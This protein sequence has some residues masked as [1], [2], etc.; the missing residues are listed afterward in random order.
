[1]KKKNVLHLILL[2]LFVIP[3]ALNAQQ[4][5]QAN[6]SAKK[7]STRIQSD[8]TIGYATPS[9]EDTYRADDG[10]LRAAP[11][12]TEIPNAAAPAPQPKAAE[13]VNVILRAPQ[14]ITN[15]KAEETKIDNSTNP[16]NKK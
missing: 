16:L 5:Q 11:A 9:S 13:P 7:I 12:S 4:T 14:P 8:A 6:A 15:R 3:V 2:L 10:T 1:M